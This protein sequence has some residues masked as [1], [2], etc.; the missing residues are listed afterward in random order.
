M[1]VRGL[2]RRSATFFAKREAIVA[3]ERRLTFEE[4]WRRGLRMANALLSLGLEPGDRVAILDDNTVG[5]VD[6]FLGAA[7]ANQI[8]R[9]HV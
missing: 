2:M 3:G 4:A 1:D 9:A 7:A 5:S 8:G 6:L